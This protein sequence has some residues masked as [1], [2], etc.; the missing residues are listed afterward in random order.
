MIQSKMMSAFDPVP[1]GPANS[2][3]S[4][5]LSRLQRRV[6]LRK[7]RDFGSGYV[8]LTDPLPSGYDPHNPCRINDGAL[9]DLKSRQHASTHARRCLLCACP[10]YREELCCP[11]CGHKR[12]FFGML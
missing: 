10:L 4:A 5:A 8:R 9:L 3:R 7:M 12:V 1:P 2:A 6:L 11:F